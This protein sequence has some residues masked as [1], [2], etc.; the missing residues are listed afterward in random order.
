MKQIAALVL[1]VLPFTLKAQ[2]WAND[3]RFTT[4]SWNV[5][6]V[7]YEAFPKLHF[8]AEGQMRSQKF[9]D[10]LNYWE[11]KTFFHY[12]FTE[13]LSGGL[14]VGTYHQYVDY[15]NFRTPQKQTENRVWAE[16][17]LKTNGK[18]IQF[19][20]RYRFEYRFIQK[21]NSALDGFTSNYD[22][23]TDEDRYRFRYRL[24]AFV[25]INHKTMQAKTFYANVSNEIMF[26]HKLPYFNQNRFFVGLGYKMQHSSIQ[27][28]L[29]HQ[30]LKLTG[31]ERRKDYLQITYAHVFK[32]TPHPKKEK[33]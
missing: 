10:D 15:E 27:I 29:M 6:N 23:T 30:F 2:G 16:F 4:G 9:Y 32:R 3:T 17:L 33:I 12:L 13:Q 26:T 5:V 25:P 14:G 20:H 31:T 22:G 28:G 1:L 19:D 21:W 8:I 18:R 7:R 11:L 24:Q